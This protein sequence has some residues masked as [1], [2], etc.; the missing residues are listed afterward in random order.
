MTDTDDKKASRYRIDLCD[1]YFA[2][3]DQYCYALYCTRNKQA[4]VARPDVNTDETIDVNLGYYTEINS[5][6]WAVVNNKVDAKALGKKSAIKLSEYITM[7][8]NIRDEVM[9]AVKI[10]E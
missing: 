6:L 2:M 8:Q 3:K 9:N 1:G 10:N 4:T 7:Y 5:M